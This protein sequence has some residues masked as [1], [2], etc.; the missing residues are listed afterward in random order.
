MELRLKLGY[1]QLLELIKQLPASQLLK[2]KS[3]LD[4]PLIEEK[5]LKD[6]TD[7]Q[8]L[9]INGPLMSDEQFDNFQQNRINFARWRSK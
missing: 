6:L 9:I 4:S 8:K 3:E 2:L 1:E 7:L 5:I